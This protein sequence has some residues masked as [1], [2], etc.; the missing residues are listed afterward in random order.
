[1]DLQITEE[2]AD[3][4]VGMFKASTSSPED[5]EVQ[6]IRAMGKVMTSLYKDK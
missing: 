5:Q 6:V 1:M 4:F 3:E 2:A